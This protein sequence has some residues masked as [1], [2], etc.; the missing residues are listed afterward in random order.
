MARN[1][2]D[3]D[4]TVR[5]VLNIHTSGYNPYIDRDHTLGGRMIMAIALG[6]GFAFMLGLGLGVC[7][8]RAW[9]VIEGQ[10]HAHAQFQDMILSANKELGPNEINGG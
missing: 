9:G 10:E 4:R 3:A 6:V 5:L 8:G 7:L 2:N 1:Q